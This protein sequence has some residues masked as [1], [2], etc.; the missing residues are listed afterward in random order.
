MAN[1]PTLDKEGYL[2]ELKDWN[3]EV[4]NYLAL[5]ENIILG[6]SHW[7]IIELLRKFYRR[8]QMSPATRALVSLVKKE[9]GSHKGRSTYIMKLFKG[10]PA[11]TASKIAGLPRP[12]NCI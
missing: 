6:S 2:I 4:A 1:I 5:R 11:K 3:V 7:E 8:H 10:N 12:S 9:L